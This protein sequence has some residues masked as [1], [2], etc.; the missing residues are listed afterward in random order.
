MLERKIVLPGDVI[1]ATEEYEAGEGT[2]ESE[3]QIYAAMPG[4]L[5]LDG[6]NFVAR[7]QPFNDTS[8]LILGSDDDH[9]ERDFVRRL[10][11]SVQ[12]PGKPRNERER[13]RNDDSTRQR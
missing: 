9:A 6:E 10:L 8:G 12:E 2:Y 5:D 4:I 3:G 1:A 13:Q 11:R 7:V